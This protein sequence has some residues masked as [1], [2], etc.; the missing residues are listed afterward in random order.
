[1]LIN[2]AI[3]YASIALVV[4]VPIFATALGQARIGKSA[5]AALDQQPT[6]DSGIKKLFF[7]AIALS[8]TVALIAL[9][10][11]AY[12]FVNPLTSDLQ[13]YARVGS[14]LAVIIPAVL[15][16]Y[17][18]SRSSVQALT[19]AARQPTLSNQ[20][21]SFT[22]ITQSLMQTPVIFCAIFAFIIQSQAATLTTY[23]S[24]LQ[25]FSVGLMLALCS[26]GPCIGLSS[27]I[28]RA[29]YALKFNRAAY[30]KLFSFTFI[31]QA[32]IETPFLLG[33]A[34]AIVVLQ[35]EVTTTIKGIAL[36]CAAVTLGVTSMVVSI[37][38]ARVSSQV[39]EGIAFSPDRAPLLGR[40][41]LFCQAFVDTTAIYGLIIA[42]L[43]I[44]R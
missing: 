9:L 20:I 27:F 1:M 33:L 30:G 6:N 38:S 31:S 13:V 14:V 34:A 26:V 29:S 42:L 3:H 5:L 4:I 7:A 39:L 19:S 44:T 22:L 24:A 25:L 23:P 12:F 37:A 11:A 36:I 16:G 40:F 28:A 15:I 35:L 2:A 18:G 8:E 43:F 17:L 41:S 10:M 32:I 21:L